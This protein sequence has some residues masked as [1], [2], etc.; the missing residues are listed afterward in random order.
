MHT[1]WAGRNA[2]DRSPWR[3][4]LQGDCIDADHHII[5]RVNLVKDLIVGTQV[6]SFA[7]QRAFIGALKRRAAGRHVLTDDH[8]IIAK[9]CVV[10]NYAR[11]RDAESSSV[12]RTGM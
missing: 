3:I 6:D 9:F 4:V 12:T 1:A 2:N 5:T 8:I 11:F 7:D 10:V